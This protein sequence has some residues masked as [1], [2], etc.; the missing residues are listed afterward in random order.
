MLQRS[1]KYTSQIPQ[2]HRSAINALGYGTS[3]VGSGTYSQQY[4]AV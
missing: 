3:Q 4:L 2:D 1:Y